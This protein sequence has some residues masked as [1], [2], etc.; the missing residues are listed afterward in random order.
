L[1]GTYQELNQS[2]QSE[3]AANQVQIR[4][5]QNRLEVTLVNDI[6]YPEG[7]WELS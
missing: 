3:V 7:G 6:L 4:Q 5:L 1:N 2:L